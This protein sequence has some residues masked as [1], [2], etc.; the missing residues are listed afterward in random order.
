M[1]G[2]RGGGVER[3]PEKLRER[4]KNEMKRV[5]EQGDTRTQCQGERECVRVYVCV[6]VCVCVHEQGAG[7]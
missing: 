4:K 2:W 3:S 7:G 5:R 6:C 1:W